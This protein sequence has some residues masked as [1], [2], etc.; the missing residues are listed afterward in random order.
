VLSLASSHVHEE[1]KQ[2]VAFIFEQRPEGLGKSWRGVDNAK[3]I[4]GWKVPLAFLM[5]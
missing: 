1:K 2:G 4:H 3:A 5:S